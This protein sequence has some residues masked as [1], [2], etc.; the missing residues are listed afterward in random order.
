MWLARSSSV[1]CFPHHRLP[2]GSPSVSSLI[3]ISFVS[4]HPCILISSTL[5]AIRVRCPPRLYYPCSTRFFVSFTLTLDSSESPFSCFDMCILLLSH[6]FIRSSIHPSIHAY[7]AHYRTVVV[8]I[9][10]IRYDMILVAIFVAVSFFS[11]L[12]LP[13]IPSH[14]TQYCT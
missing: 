1:P 11:P 6:T 2:I 7:V 12:S 13:S 4:N 10:T 14:S 3:T 9:S 5:H 8:A